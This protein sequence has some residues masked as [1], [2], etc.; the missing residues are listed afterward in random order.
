MVA[1]FSYI[2]KLFDETNSPT[3]YLACRIVWIV[4]A[5]ISV[6]YSY[7]WDIKYDWGILEKNSKFMILRNKLS[8][9]KPM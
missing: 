6:L 1:T 7:Y 5:T 3:P 8:Y 2:Y 4:F 9:H